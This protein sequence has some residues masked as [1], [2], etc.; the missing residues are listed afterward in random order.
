[1]AGRKL[2]TNIYPHS[3]GRGRESVR[4]VVFVGNSPIHGGT[5]PATEAGIR[6]AEKAAESIRKMQKRRR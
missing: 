6:K 5:F 2:P 3:N 1:M 4:V